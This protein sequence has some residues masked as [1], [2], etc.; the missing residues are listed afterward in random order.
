M[1]WKT[2]SHQIKNFNEGG[3]LRGVGDL[4]D[5]V[6]LFTGNETLF[7]RKPVHFDL[8]NVIVSRQLDLKLDWSGIVFWNKSTSGSK[9]TNLNTLLS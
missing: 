1:I 9:F 7:S 5:E 4:Q 6:D 2:I 3:V 8:R